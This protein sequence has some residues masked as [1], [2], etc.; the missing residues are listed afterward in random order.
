MT[1]S[2]AQ[3]PTG[4]EHPRPVKQAIGYGRGQAPVSPARIT[5]SGKTP[6]QHTFG[7]EPGT[8]RGQRHRFQRQLAK[9]ERGGNQMRMGVDQSGHQRPAFEIDDLCL[10]RRNRPV[11]YL[12]DALFFYQDMHAF[13]QVRRRTVQQCAVL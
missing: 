6:P 3:G 9:V 11:R 8:R 10:R 2:L 7:N 12:A 13:A 1:A 4:I 5:D